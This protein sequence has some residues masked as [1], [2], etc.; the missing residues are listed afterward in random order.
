[1]KVDYLDSDD[2]IR[3]QSFACLSFLC[4]EQFMAAKEA[5]FAH[6]FLA[7]VG[8]EVRLLLENLNPMC[9]PEQR[10][11]LTRIRENHSYLWTADEVQEKFRAFTNLNTAS[12]EEE[13]HVS[14][15]RANTMR[16]VKVR[17]VYSSIE[18]ARDRARALTAKDP[19]HNV[20]VGEVGTWLPLT[21]NPEAA[22]DSVYAESSLN[23]LMQRYN[24]NMACKEE[25]FNSRRISGKADTD[26]WMQSRQIEQTPA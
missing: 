13:F 8:Q 20:W 6:R 10:D 14:N 9:G 2:P 16:G 7:E 11:M 15:G 19:K 22:K 1:M 24:E 21:D 5:F 26:P 25:H 18:E 4:P 23:E 12:L 17:G 3:G